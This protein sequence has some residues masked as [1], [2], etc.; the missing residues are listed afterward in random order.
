MQMNGDTVTVDQAW[1]IA[2]DME[3]LALAMEH[4][5]VELGELAIQI[6]EECS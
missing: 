5:T 2:N 3:E 6:A 1:R 4:I